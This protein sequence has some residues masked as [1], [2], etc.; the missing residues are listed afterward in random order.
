[1]TSSFC[2]CDIAIEK[3]QTVKISPKSLT[4]IAAIPPSPAPNI[5]RFAHTEL[6]LN[7]RFSLPSKPHPTVR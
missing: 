2:P 3:N 5:S 7:R 4:S 1:S 6:I